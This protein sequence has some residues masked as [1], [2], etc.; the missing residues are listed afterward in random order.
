MMN[1]IP[2]IP[3]VA[4]IDDDAIYRKVI[5]HLLKKNNLTI[6]FEAASGPE[7]IGL[8]QQAMRLPDIIIIDVEMPQMDGFETAK[9]LKKYWPQVKII[10]NSGSLDPSVSDKMMAAGADRFMP[11]N[12]NSLKIAKLIQEVYES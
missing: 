5:A 9:M 1:P 11:K 7:S 2:K 4:I 3:T 10:A 6:L 8:M 12:F